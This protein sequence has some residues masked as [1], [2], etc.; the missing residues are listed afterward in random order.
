MTKE[1]TIFFLCCCIGILIF[2][3][4]Y[5]YIVFNRGTQTKLKEISEKLKEIL[6]T[7]SDEKIMVFTGNKELMELA[8]QINELLENRSVDCEALAHKTEA[9]IFFSRRRCRVIVIHCRN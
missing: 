8:A 6:E 5:Q 3:V 9:L 2:I 4:I 1:T 7:Q